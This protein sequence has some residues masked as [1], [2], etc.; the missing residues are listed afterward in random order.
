MK[1][2]CFVI[3][4]SRGDPAHAG[5]DE[6]CSTSAASC[7]RRCDQNRS[8]HLCIHPRR[9]VTLDVASTIDSIWRRSEQIFQTVTPATASAFRLSTFSSQLCTENRCTQQTPPPPRD[10]AE[11][12]SCAGQ[13]HLSP[14]SCGRDISLVSVE[15]HAPAVPRS[16][17]FHSKAVRL[18]CVFSP[19]LHAPPPPQGS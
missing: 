5:G 7:V 11:P 16:P 4:R 2:L 9:R 18:M 17:V 19:S 1:P 3:S 8:S 10:V 14:S 15:P 13:K 12:F 6:L